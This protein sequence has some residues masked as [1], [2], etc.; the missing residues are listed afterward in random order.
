VNFEAALEALAARGFIL[1]YSVAGVEYGQVADWHEHQHING[2]ERASVLP[3]P[4]A[5]PASDVRNAIITSAPEQPAPETPPTPA[6]EHEA[7][8]DQVEGELMARRAR[9]AHRAAR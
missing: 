6:G 4:A 5:S 9:A 1:R 3:A 2:R 7:G 8:W